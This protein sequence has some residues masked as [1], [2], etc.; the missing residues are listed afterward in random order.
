MIV[1]FRYE[2]AFLDTDSEESGQKTEI[3]R[4][5]VRYRALKLQTRLQDGMLDCS[6]QLAVRQEHQFGASLKGFLL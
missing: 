2:R 6:L 4:D 1:S 5:G 3:N